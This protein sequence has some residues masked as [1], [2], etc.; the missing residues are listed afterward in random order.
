MGFKSD[1]DKEAYASK[2]RS[3]GFSEDEISSDV[4]AIEADQPAPAPVAPPPPIKP[5]SN[6]GGGGSPMTQPE[7]A[8]PP[9]SPAPASAAISELKDLQQ[10]RKEQDMA[11]DDQVLNSTVGKMAAG[12]ALAYGLPKA[13][14]L[15]GKFFG[16]TEPQ[17]PFNASDIEL[18][19]P[20]SREGKLPTQAQINESEW[21]ANLSPQE[22]Q[23]LERSEAAKAA[24]AAAPVAAPAPAPVAV[25]EPVVQPAAANPKAP[26]LVQPPAGAVAPP[27]A[28]PV[29]PVAPTAAPAEVAPA[30][31]VPAPVE[32]APAP[33]AAKPAKAPKPEYFEGYK[34]LPGTERQVLGTFGVAK[35]TERAKTLVNA[36]KSTLPEGAALEFPKTEAGVS[37]GGMPNPQDVMSFTNKHLG[38][39][40]KLDEKGKFPADFRYT[41]ENLAKM[42]QSVLDEYANAKTP[43]AKAAAEKGFATLRSLAGLA[44]FGALAYGSL[45]A[46][47]HGKKTGDWTPAGE[48]GINTI[49]G[50]I[51]PALMLGTHMTGLN[52]G[53]EQELAKRRYNAMVGGGR[54]VAPPS[55]YQR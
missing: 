17:K 54:G 25:P 43:A 44:G 4:Q 15:I 53:E 26:A 19:E 13:G 1:K 23:M 14:K 20:V 50:A 33:E 48:L 51:N 49:A 16:E 24:K 32:V 35:D 34:K 29:I 7:V 6:F 9:M 18:G 10:A 27:V 28:E 37:K 3:A 22:Q 39:D 11:L 41:E 52:S 30:P 45:E 40:M 12:A 21:R 8:P 55:T 46:Y 2:L 36:L 47:K 31:A 42:H 38:T 5:S